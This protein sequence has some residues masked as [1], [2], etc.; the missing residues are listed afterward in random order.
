MTQEP[1]RAGRWRPVL[2]WAGLIGG[3]LLVTAAAGVVVAERS[4]IADALAAVRRPAP[5]L[6]ALLAGTIVLNVV[7]TGLVFT[8][9][10]S[11]YGRV[12]LG[13]MQAL[14]AA[15]ALLNYVPLRPGLL[16][17]IVYHRTFN[18]IPAMATVKT[19]VRAFVL[20]IALSAYVALALVAVGRLSAP[21]WAAVGLPVPV[22]AVTAFVPAARYWG[23][24]A[25]LRYLELFVLA[26][27]YHAAFALIGSP[28]EPPV[29]LA[30]ACVSMVAGL[31]PFAGNGLGLREWAIGLAAP[32]LTPYVLGQGLAAD[33][34]VRAAELVVVAVLGLAG[35]AWLYSS[36]RRSALVKSASKA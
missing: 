20:T 5:A 11:R 22:L 1:P 28:L 14:I 36:M 6:V 15:A 2:R 4:T 12:G 19:T 16:G 34:L 25:L 29:A 21:L 24:A 18:D 9:L 7:M 23:V 8:V 35:V 27:R 10:I 17:R 31:V 32:L 26:V 30:F 3:L 13:E 33:L